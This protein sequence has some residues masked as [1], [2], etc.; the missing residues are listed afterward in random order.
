LAYKKYNIHSLYKKQALLTCWDIFGKSYN[1]EVEMDSGILN[2]QNKILHFYDNFQSLKSECG[3]FSMTKLI[4][5]T[6]K[7]MP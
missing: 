6:F 3:L 2:L 5:N 7:N 1:T 4:L